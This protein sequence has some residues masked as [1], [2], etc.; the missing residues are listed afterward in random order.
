MPH[1]HIQLAQAPNGELGRVATLVVCVSLLVTP[2]WST[3]T[4]CVGNTM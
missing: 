3:N 2:W 1:E 4:T